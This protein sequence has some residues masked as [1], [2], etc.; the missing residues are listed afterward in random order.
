MMLQCRLH[1]GV[2]IGRLVQGVSHGHK[3]ALSCSKVTEVLGGGTGW[4]TGKA[5]R[6]LRAARGAKRG[7]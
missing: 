5:L 3:V 6:C 2:Q 7:K 4:C 1:A